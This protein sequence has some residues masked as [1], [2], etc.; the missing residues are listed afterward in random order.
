MA[1]W[2]QYNPFGKRDSHSNNTIL[3]YKILTLIT[4]ILSLV[5][6]V[7][8][9][10]HRPDDGHTR[11]RKIWEQNHM[12]RTAF[13]LNPIITSIYWIVLFILQAG[14]IGHLF[15]SNADIVHAA[16]SVGSHFIFNNLFHFAFV[17]LFVR[18]HF[19]WAEVILI[20]NFINLSS[21]YFRHNTYPRFI[22][23]PVVSGPLAWTFVAIYWNG[24]LMIP[25][26]HHLVPRIFGNI[27]IW[28]ILA[29]GL[30][31]IIIYKD[32]TMGFS[33][34]VFAAAIGVSQFLHQVIAFQWIFAFVIMALLFVATVVV[35][36]PAA[37]GREVN[38]R[39][40]PADQERAP[41]LAERSLIDKLP[42]LAAQS[43][44]KWKYIA[45]PGLQP[46][47]ALPTARQPHNILSSANEACPRAVRFVNRVLSSEE[48][49]QN[50]ARINI[51]N[52]AKAQ[53][54]RSKETLQQENKASRSHEQIAASN[55]EMWSC[56]A[57]IA[58]RFAAK[59]AVMKAHPH[60]RLTFHDVVIERR[61]VE[62]ARLGSG[63]PIARIRSG[64]GEEE[65]T[66][67]LVSISH[68]GD[69]ATAHAE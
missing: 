44:G 14:Y 64:E 61:P 16:A 13:T 56:A 59:E 46:T 24:A 31:F 18:S 12:Y 8:Y 5:V 58:G 52:S 22:H 51:L 40:A 26:P 6:T 35:A 60:R 20:L 43:S 17:M 25:H 3:T 15:S 4:W 69:Y 23:T 19:H 47:K 41:L 27:F 53:R 33:L 11:N 54:S 36:V 63:P 2:Q 32:Y 28:S 42:T 7:Y 39:S 49:A 48:L 38:W 67:A 50:D 68:D 1:N 62:G 9:T 37:T 29:Y 10:L 21:L 65:D 66:S 57:F 34:S 45:K 55:P 30:F